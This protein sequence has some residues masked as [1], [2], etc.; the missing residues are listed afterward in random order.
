[1]FSFLRDLS[2]Q[3]ELLKERIHN[4][5]IPLSPRGQRIMGFVYFCIPV[6]GGYWIMQAAIGQSQKNLASKASLTVA[7]KEVREQNVALQKI[8]DSAQRKNK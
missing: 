8:L 5:R 3:H 1:M 6:I 4:F 7:S 2:A